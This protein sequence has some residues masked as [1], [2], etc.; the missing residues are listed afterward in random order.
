[1]QDTTVCL[2]ALTQYMKL[3]G[4]NSQNTV[5]LSTEDSEEVF[6]VDNNNRLLVQRSKLS[7]RHGQYTVD[8]EGEGCAFT[9]VMET[10]H[11]GRTEL[12]CESSDQLH[13]KSFVILL[14]L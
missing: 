1:M 7:A 11:R 12:A 6:P 13:V 3:T 14:F 5:T 8:V 9:Q 10:L 4:S 2:L